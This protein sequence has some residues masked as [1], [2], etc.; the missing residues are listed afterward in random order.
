MRGVHVSVH[1]LLQYEYSDLVHN[2]IHSSAQSIRLLAFGPTRPVLR[3][4]HPVLPPTP[5]QEAA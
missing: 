1:C 4:T 3:P 5:Q 2:P